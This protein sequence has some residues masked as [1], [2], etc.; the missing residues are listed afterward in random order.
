MHRTLVLKH[1]AILQNEVKLLHRAHLVRQIII[2]LALRLLVHLAGG[3]REIHT[4]GVDGGHA[5]HHH[6]PGG[7][8]ITHAHVGLGGQPLERCADGAAVQVQLR[9]LRSGLCL[10]Y[11]GFRHGQGCLAAALGMLRIRKLLFGNRAA[12]H[13]GG[14]SLQ[15]FLCLLICHLRLQHARFGGGHIRQSLVIRGLIVGGV[16]A[17]EHLILLT[18]GAVPV[19]L[20]QKLAGYLRADISLVHTAQVPEPGGSQVHRALLQRHHGHIDGSHSLPGCLGP[21]FILACHQSGACHQPAEGYHY[22]VACFH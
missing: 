17:E 11:L 18:Q 3:H 22:Y 19:H 6:L 15:V 9:H 12:L 10:G 16:D 4:D 21:C 5:G 1:A 7:H 20:L 13:K 8:K 14:E 2:V